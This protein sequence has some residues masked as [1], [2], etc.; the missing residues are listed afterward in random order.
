MGVNFRLAVVGHRSSVEEIKEIVAN[1]FEN[2]ETVGIEMASDEMTGEA[3]KV[4]RGLLPKLDGVLYTRNEPYKLIVSRLDHGGVLARYVDVDAA[5]FVQSLLI[6]SLNYNADIYRVSVDTLDYTTVMKTYDSLEVDMERV[7]PVMV[8]VDTNARHFV[9]ATAQAH[10]ESY[11]NGL[12]SICITNIRNVQDTLAAEGI[13]CVLMTPS[14]DNYINEIRRLMFHWQVEEKTKQNTVV[15]RIR[16]ELSGDY[17]L[18]RKTMVQ[19]VLDLSKLSEAIVM[20]AQMIS[21]AYARMGEQ[22]FIIVCSYEELSEATDKFSHIDLLAEVYS[23]TPYRLAVGIGAGI[24]LQ[25]A[26]ANAELGTQRAWAEGCN[27]AYLVFTEGRSIGPIQPN[28][29]LHITHDQIDRQLTKAAQ[30]CALST[31][32]VSKIDTF[33]RRKNNGSFI[34]A[35]LAEEL[36]VSFRTAARIVEKLEKNGYAVEIGRTVINGR[37]RP[38]RVFRLLW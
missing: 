7:R 9:D 18:N 23:S 10:R 24:N 11:R 36:C 19:N 25:K 6:A 28:E 5:S 33:V 20:F 29:L 8:S 30:D 34:T 17:Y 37:G 26:L 16:A 32:T 22:D 27:R 21:G 12:C 4:L 13:P 3:V 1:T 15:M 35:D 2:I 31:N 38:T 14:P